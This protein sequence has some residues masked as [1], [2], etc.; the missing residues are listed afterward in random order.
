MVPF[1]AEVEKDEKGTPNG[2]CNLHSKYQLNLYCLQ[3]NKNICEACQEN[4]HV[5][6][7]CRNINDMYQECRHTLETDLELL[8]S[9][10]SDFL[11][12][13]RRLSETQTQFAE[14]A[15]NTEEDLKQNASEINYC[16]EE[17][18]SKLMDKL[19]NDKTQ[20]EKRLGGDRC[21]LEFIIAAI[22][23]LTMQIDAVLKNERPCD[24]VGAFHDLHSRTSKLH[25]QQKGTID[26]AKLHIGV[27]MNDLF[28]EIC[29][30][31]TT[32]CT[33]QG[34]SMIALYYC[35]VTFQ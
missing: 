21:H 14:R 23:T 9:Q 10:E 30:F 28:D 6:H 8:A 12:E 1:A 35:K 31:M 29:D 18:L 5:N 7:E 27:R 20:I 19:N 33:H 2:F 13:K 3:C 32:K 22:K 16:V 26:Y 34:M 25:R 11:R 4:S 17:V 24:I 15:R